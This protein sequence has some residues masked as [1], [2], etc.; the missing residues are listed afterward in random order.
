MKPQLLS[1]KH[2][3]GRYAVPRKAHVARVAMT[4]RH[5]CQTHSIYVK[6]VD[7]LVFNVLLRGGNNSHFS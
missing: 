5:N 3:D 2:T 6:G 1:Q 7:A 4:L